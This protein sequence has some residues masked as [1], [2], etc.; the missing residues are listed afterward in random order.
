L[1][2][3]ALAATNGNVTAA[4]KKLGISRRTLHRKIN[5][6]NLAKKPAGRAGNNRRRS[7]HWLGAVSEPL[8]QRAR[9][10]A[11]ASPLQKIKLSDDWHAHAWILSH[12]WPEQFSESRILQLAQPT[13]M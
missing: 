7:W 2:A 4:A 12:G 1:I 11:R 10:R 5:E 8:M 13:W 9:G 3:Q 6:M